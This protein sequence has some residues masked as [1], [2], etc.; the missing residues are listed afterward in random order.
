MSRLLGRLAGMIPK[1]PTT[2][3]II[4][5]GNVLKKS[6]IIYRGFIPSARGKGTF[7]PLIRLCERH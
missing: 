6:H 5:V 3:G 7:N 4:Y 2:T 1:A